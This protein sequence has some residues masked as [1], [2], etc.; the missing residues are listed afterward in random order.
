[1]NDGRASGEAAAQGEH[2]LVRAIGLRQFTASIVNVTVGAG[3]FVATGAA[4]LRVRLTAVPLAVGIAA[5]WNFPVQ[6]SSH[7][8]APLISQDPL[9]DNT[10]VYA[11]VSPDRPGYV[12]LIANYN[13]FVAPTL[14][15]AP[16]QEP[17]LA[18]GVRMPAAKSW[19]ADR[20]GD[21]EVHEG[22]R[23]S[24]IECQHRPFPAKQTHR[25]Q[26]EAAEQHL[27][28]IVPV[29]LAQLHQLG[30]A[31]LVEGAERELPL[32]CTWVP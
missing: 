8:E 9:A 24:R 6:A 29:G 10:D 28:R 32:T 18:P 5:L 16:R 14:E 3:I 12:T 4:A 27:Q 31:R 26:T 7:R 19:R 30:P 17:N 21:D 22:A 15:D 20:P 13:P 1:M 23:R 11:F 25:G 2:G